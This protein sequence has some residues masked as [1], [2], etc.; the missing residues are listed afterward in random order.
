MRILQLRPFGPSLT[1][2]EIEEFEG[3][4]GYRLPQDYRL[5]LLR[6][7]GGG[8][9]AEF[10][11]E[12][13]WRDET[14]VVMGFYA[15]LPTTDRGLRRVLGDLSRLVKG[16]LP[17]T[18]DTGQQ[19]ICLPISGGRRGVYLAEY[20]YEADY[21]VAAVMHRLEDSFTDFVNNLK[22]VI[23]PHDDIQ[24]LGKSAKADEVDVFL[25]SGRSIDELSM[26]GSSIL[27]EAI[28]YGNMPLIGACIEKG[29]DLSHAIHAAVQSRRIEAIEL[30]VRAGAD[31][32]ERDKFGERPLKYVVGTALPG[33]EGA[34]NRSLRETLIRLGAIE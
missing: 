19:D 18:S 26:Y 12:Y 16:Y 34:R 29:A 22:E 17:I 7:N 13:T 20:T 32:N 2:R 5:F 4:I 24:E 9:A 28:K 6:H 21:P 30:L 33:D 27:C 1:V 25:R 14:L 31:I 3:E 8:G 10:A 11:L 23:V 15:L